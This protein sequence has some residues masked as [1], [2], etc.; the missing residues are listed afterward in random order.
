MRALSPRR[1]E[2]SESGTPRQ[3]G[4]SPEACT[5]D[6][7]PAGRL[8]ALLPMLEEA[9]SRWNRREWIAPDPLELVLPYEAPED[10]ET[11]AFIASSLAYGRVA[12]IVKSASSLLAS[13]G[14][15]PAEFLRGASPA[16]LRSLCSSFRHRFTTG[17]EMGG[18]LVALGDILR[19]Y[20]SIE[21]FLS[22]YMAEV[23]DLVQALSLFSEELRLK[24]GIRRTFLL[25]SPAGGSACKRLFL[26][27]KWMVR[28]DAVDPGGWTLLSPADLILP[29][30]VHMFRICSALGLTSR[31]Q[32]DLKAALEATAA[33]RAVLPSDPLKFDFVLTRY[34]IRQEMDE[35][36]FIQKCLEGQEE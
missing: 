1:G 30:D 8:P 10:R 32:P 13:L 9:Y 35:K 22:R 12:Q 26:F 4:G 28:R 25:P 24:A 5:H 14:P 2:D 18:L 33:F 23:Q 27:L 19:E 7:P 3:D 29:L 11:A 34:G 21:K 15:S 17:E 36:V 16:R 6:L 20:G 31:R